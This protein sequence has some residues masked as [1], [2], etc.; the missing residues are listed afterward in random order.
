[1]EKREIIMKINLDMAGILQQAERLLLDSVQGVDQRGHHLGNLFFDMKTYIDNWA[2]YMYKTNNYLTPTNTG[3]ITPE[4]PSKSSGSIDSDLNDLI[5]LNEPPVG[6]LPERIVTLPKQI[7]Q[8]VAWVGRNPLETETNFFI[9]ASL[10]TEIFENWSDDAGEKQK[11]LA[12]PLMAALLYTVMERSAKIYDKKREDAFQ[13]DALVKQIK[14]LWL[15]CSAVHTW[16]NWFEMNAPEYPFG[17]WYLLTPARPDA[18]WR[19]PNADAF[20]PANMQ[21]LLMVQPRFPIIPTVNKYLALCA[22]ENELTGGHPDLLYPLTQVVPEPLWQFMRSTIHDP[23]WTLELA[24]HD[25]FTQQ[26]ARKMVDA[27][28]MVLN[29]HSAT[30]LPA[31]NTRH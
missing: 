9:A 30:T 22:F 7:D 1:M 5:E 25:L 21:A 11:I 27:I 26:A 13:L 31:V 4:E 17:A 10:F 28:K 14:P 12:C 24:N 20:G 8:L 15:M 29:L 3:Q 2:T 23:G 16:A 18:W 6:T 19:M